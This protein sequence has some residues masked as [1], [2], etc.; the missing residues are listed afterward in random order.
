MG[1]AT[2]TATETTMERAT[3]PQNG[4]ICHIEF[5]TPDLEKA[6]AFYSQLFGWEFQ[7]FQPT[8]WYFMTPKNWGPCGCMLQGPAAAD[9]RTMIYVNVADIG[10]ALAQASK[11]GATTT[12]QKT[13]IPGGHGFFAQLKAPDGNVWGIY[14][15]S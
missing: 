15:R 1:N 12:K 11:L 8:E 10:K 6:R 7:P 3:E 4:S 13:E 2:A 14:S 9:A 5:T